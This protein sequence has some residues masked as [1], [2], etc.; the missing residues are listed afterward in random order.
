MSPNESVLRLQHTLVYALVGEWCTAALTVTASLAVAAALGV[1][2][3]LAV[4]VGE[5]GGSRGGAWQ[6]HATI[7][8]VDLP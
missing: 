4:A 5:R 1:T 2:A 3:A 6:V 8:G 7:E